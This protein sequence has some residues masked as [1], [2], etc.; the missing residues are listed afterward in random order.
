[1]KKHV[2]TIALELG[3]LMST[4]GCAEEKPPDPADCENYEIEVRFLMEERKIDPRAMFFFDEFN[5]FLY[6]PPKRICTSKNERSECGPKGNQKSMAPQRSRGRDT[7]SCA[8]GLTPT[9]VARVLII[10]KNVSRE[11]L[12]MVNTDLGKHVLLVKNE[13]GNV[14]GATHI[15]IVYNRYLKTEVPKMKE[16]LG[17]DQS[18][19]WFYGEDHATG[20][21]FDKSKCGRRGINNQRQQF[22]KSNNGWRKLTPKKGTPRYM[23]GDQLHHVFKV[24]VH[25]RLDYL[26][27]VQK[28]LK[29]CK[30]MED[31]YSRGGIFVT[32]SGVNR[33]PPMYLYCLAVAIEKC[34]LTKHMVLASFCKCGFF[35]VKKASKLFGMTEE[36]IAEGRYQLDNEQKDLSALHIFLNKKS[37]FTGQPSESKYVSW[38]SLEQLDQHVNPALK[39]RSLFLL[40]QEESEKEELL[41]RR[42][43]ALDERKAFKMEPDLDSEQLSQPIIPAKKQRGPGCL[44][45]FG[46][47]ADATNAAE[48]RIFRRVF[49]FVFK[50][51]ADFSKKT[52]HFQQLV[53]DFQLYVLKRFF[54]ERRQ[55]GSPLA[56]DTA[57]HEYVWKILAKVNRMNY[58][59]KEAMLKGVLQDFKRYSLTPT[60]R[61]SANQGDED[62]DSESSTGEDKKPKKAWKPKMQTEISRL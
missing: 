2:S 22:F 1:M 34:Y 61:R 56:A 35:D 21:Y 60:G 47:V 62:A 13:T 53:A 50:G 4:S 40:C 24:R 23:V 49:L 31:L 32:A 27:G 16:M 29:K 37:H 33:A 19:P 51:I 48:I 26:M 41:K 58:R 7:V 52:D 45:K 3:I 46:S 54:L 59:Y 57:M 42:P 25:K 17:L 55:F 18:E 20:H 9:W 44:A 5:D 43:L 6:K 15:D 28:D 30:E 10:T 38:G 39:E 8:L 14:D 12:D 36:L 11:Q